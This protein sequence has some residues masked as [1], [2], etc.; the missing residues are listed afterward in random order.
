MVSMALLL[1]A[2][3]AHHK[4]SNSQLYCRTCTCLQLPSSHIC[5]IAVNAALDLLINCPRVSQSAVRT[6]LPRS[7]VCVLRL[8]VAGLLQLETQEVALHPTASFVHDAP[9]QL[10]QEVAVAELPLCPVLNKQRQHM[11][12]QGCALAHSIGQRKVA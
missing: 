7:Q 11:R 5:I 4:P 9:V 1:T 2:T 3:C 10:Q 8:Q 6:I 12:L